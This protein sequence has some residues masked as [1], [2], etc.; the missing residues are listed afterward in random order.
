MNIFDNFESK[1]TCGVV[2]NNQEFLY[3][4]LGHTSN[5][6]TYAGIRARTTGAPQNHWFGPG[7][8][9]RG[10]GIGTSEAIK[11]VWSHH[12]EIVFDYLLPSN[13]TLTQS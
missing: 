12:R 10:G 9:P 5:G 1:L 11:S 7:G 6:T 8:D 13:L 2:S 4:V 3:K